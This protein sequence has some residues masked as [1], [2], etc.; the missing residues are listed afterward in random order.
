[1]RKTT[2]DDWAARFEAMASGA[3]DAW[4]AAASRLAAAG[5]LPAFWLYYRRSTRQDDGALLMVPD[6]PPPGQPWTLG[7]TQPYRCNLDRAAVRARVWTAARSLPILQSA[8]CPE[9]GQP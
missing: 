6:G 3:A 9:G 5:Q 4:H 2:P 8:D 1:M 7:D